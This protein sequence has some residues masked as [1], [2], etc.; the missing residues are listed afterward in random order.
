MPLEE[1]KQ[2]QA[3]ALAVR[4]REALPQRELSAHQT[5]G[6]D[7]A[8]DLLAQAIERLTGPDVFAAVLDLEPEQLRALRASISGDSSEPKFVVSFP[9]VELSLSDIWDEG[10]APENPTPD[11]VIQVMRDEDTSLFDVARKWLL[12]ENLYVRADSD[13]E[14]DEEVEWDGT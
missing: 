4:A 11:D 12:V 8:I 5:S 2:E 10:E 1:S 14:G 3:H 13:T 6:T 7:I 9:D